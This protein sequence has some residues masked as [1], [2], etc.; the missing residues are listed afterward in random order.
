[1]PPP[2]YFKSKTPDELINIIHALYGVIQ[3][4]KDAR[5]RDLKEHE[6]TERKLAYLERRTRVAEIRK[7]TNRILK[8]PLTDKEKIALIVQTIDETSNKYIKRK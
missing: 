4:Q 3:N 6:L 7:N 2:E 5:L 8:M 1:M